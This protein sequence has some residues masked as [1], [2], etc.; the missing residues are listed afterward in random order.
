MSRLPSAPFPVRAARWSAPTDGRARSPSAPPPLLVFSPSNKIHPETNLTHLLKHVRERH[1]QSVS[2]FFLYLPAHLQVCLFQFRREGLPPL[3]VHL[4]ISSPL[5]NAARLFLSF[6]HFS[7][8]Q[9]HTSTLCPS[10][11]SNCE[12]K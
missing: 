2:L 6:S 4:F 3:L 5:S 12:C 7:S 11:S 9:G 10:I 8:T 1:T